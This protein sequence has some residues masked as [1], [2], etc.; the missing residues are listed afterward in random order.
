[1]SRTER[2]PLTVEQTLLGFLHERPMHG[3]EIYQHLHQPTA[4]GV[5]WH[6]K[7][8]Q[9]YALLA[10]L[11]EEGYI[12]ST[13]QAQSGRPPR[14]VFELTEKGKATFSAWLKSPVARGRAFRLEFLAKL[15]FAQRESPSVLAHLLAQQRATCHAWLNEQQ[16]LMAEVTENDRYAW[17]VYRFRSGQI[18][19]ML[20]WLD[21]CAQT[22]LG[23]ALVESD[24]T[25]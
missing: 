21:E 11:E 1:M 7:Q 12:S 24:E 13:P 8:G 6:L 18:K 25:P 10:R 2:T 23:T 17:L 22:L 5:V 4:L 14:K 15:Y 19:A 20:T 16:R 3:Y 9:L